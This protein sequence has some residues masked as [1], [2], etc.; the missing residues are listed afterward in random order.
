MKEPESMDECVY[1]TRRAFAPDKGKMMA[2]ALRKE[3]PKCKKGLM[4]KPKKTANEYVCP[5]CKYE[6][7][8]AEHEENLV[9]SVKYTC[10]FCNKDGKA[11]TPFKRKTLYG[12]PAY[13][14]LC[15][16]CNEKLGIYKRMAFPKKWL[17][18]LGLS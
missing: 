12:K 14:F 5:Q 13:V 6:E 7:P 2:W 8:K 15:S 1:F 18:K 10:P 4:K 11:E 17:E 3:C 9:V 16:S